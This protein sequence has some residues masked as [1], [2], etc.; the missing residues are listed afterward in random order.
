M[1][2]SHLALTNYRN[3]NRLELDMPSGLVFVVGANAQGKSN[4]LEAAYLLALAK[5]HRTNAER[6]LVSWS[7][8]QEGDAP[9]EG[10]LITGEVEQRE[11]RLKV[12]IALRVLPREGAGG[13]LVQKQIRVN[14]AATSAVGLVGRITAVLFTASDIEL[15][16]GAPSGRRRFLDILISQVDRGYLRT[17]QRYQRVLSQRNHLLR[18]VRDGRG[19]PDELDFWDAELVKEGSVVVARRREVMEHLAPLAVDAY[20]RLSGGEGMTVV[21]Q[22]SAAAEELSDA[23]AG[24]RREEVKAGMT[25]VGPHRDDLVLHVGEMAASTYASRGQA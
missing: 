2:L 18:L 14:G 19:M 1:Y 23:L 25:L 10:T 8:Q 9:V 13:A 3:F 15:V 7:A 20:A 24:Q 11:G 6:E 21:F 22:P 16:L 4:L 5:S 17:L 12:V